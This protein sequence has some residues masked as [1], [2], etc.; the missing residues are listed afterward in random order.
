MSNAR[1]ILAMLRSRAAGDDER[2]F[3]IALQVAAAEARQGHR[4]VAEG[5][6]DAVEEARGN[7]GRGQTVAVPFAAPRG[8]LA[9][10]M[11]LR[12]PSYRLD[13]VV[14][15]EQP[16]AQINTLIREQVRRDWL[17]E[18]G[19]I[20]SQRV[21][22]LGPPGSGKTMTA[23]ALAGALKLPLLVIRLEM[24]I[25]RFMG[26]TAAKLRLVFGEMAKRRGV[27]LFDE[28]DAV[29]SHRSASNDV[30]EMRRVLNSFLQFMEEPNATDS[31]VA[32]ATNHPGL[33]DYALLRRFDLVVQFEM[34][35]DNQIRSIVKAYLRPMKY[36]RLGW[37]QIVVAGRDL[38]QSE[39]A[40]ATE[41]AV[42]T[43][44]L[45]ERDRL[46]TRDIVAAL[47]ERREMRQAFIGAQVSR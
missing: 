28:F 43:A 11:E 17:R 27:Y 30:A 33:L 4:N 31:L 6:R 36:S 12:S 45:D 38:S 18:H 2:F 39:L 16:C 46:T 23:E 10:L 37:K 8:D 15:N 25:T 32:A 42:K 40:R 5:I 34:P 21:L 44:I 7:T 29:G 20:P 9:G 35:S 22:F 1:Q 3:T 24:L 19:K 47:N 41:K 13:D 14:L 26:E